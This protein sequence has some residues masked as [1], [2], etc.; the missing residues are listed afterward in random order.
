[1]ELAIEFY[2]SLIPDSSVGWVSTISPENP[3]GPVGSV[4]IAGLTLGNHPYMAFESGP[5]D[6]FDH[7]SSITVA[8]ETQADFEELC[9]TLK[10]GGSMEPGG[11][12]QDRW[13]LRW[14]I[15]PKRSGDDVKD[16]GHVAVDKL[17]EA[18]FSVAKLEA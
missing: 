18:T 1:M 5:L 8:C 7:G 14:R 6:H 17:R 15:L 3:N 10:E 12:L 11:F 4:K 9:D 2:T 16:L 13:G